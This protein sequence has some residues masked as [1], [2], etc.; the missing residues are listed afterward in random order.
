MGN[1]IRKEKDT[2]KTLSDESSICHNRIN[3]IDILYVKRHPRHY[4]DK[5]DDST[6]Y[7]HSTYATINMK[8]PNI[9]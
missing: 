4:I 5:Y 9:D 2:T 6:I 8:K 1:C 7:Y 3:N